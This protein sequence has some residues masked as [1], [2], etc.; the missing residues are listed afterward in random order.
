MLEFEETKEAKDSHNEVRSVTNGYVMLPIDEYNNLLRIADAASNAVTLS[1]RD[2]H[3][4]K[5]I[6]A[7]IDKHWLYRLL[8]DKLHEQYSLRDLAGYEMTR[9]ADD[10]LVLDITLA[11]LPETTE[12]V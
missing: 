6:E 8:M 9:S 11:K 1:R 3:K 10:L 2:Y 12:E 4:T 7:T 5:P